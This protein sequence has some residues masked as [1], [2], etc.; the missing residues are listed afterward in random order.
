MTSLRSTTLIAERHHAADPD[1]LL[2]GGGDLVAD[3]LSR[4]LALE[5]GEGQQHVEGQSP[6]AGGGVEGL[7]D[8]DERDAVGVE[9]FDQLGEIGERTG[10]PIDLVDDDDIDLTSRH[11]VEQ[12]LQSRAVQT[13]AG[14]AAV[15]V[16]AGDKRPSFMGL[17]ADIGGA[18]LALGVEGVEVLLEALVGGDAGVDRASQRPGFRGLDV[19]RGAPAALE[20]APG[21]DGLAPRPAPDRVDRICARRVL[22]VGRLPRCER[23]RL[24]SAVRRASISALPSPDPRRRSVARST[25]SR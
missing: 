12:R 6:H 17:A 8:R 3:A 18:G 7:G 14:I 4:D 19:L 10:Q 20:R 24:G 23:E 2:L 15:V 16:A 1:A 11:G 9:R 22:M 21:H 5:L 13:A 25:A